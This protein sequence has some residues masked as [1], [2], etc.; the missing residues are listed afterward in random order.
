V[1]RWHR[2][3]A[4]TQIAALQAARAGSAEGTVYVAERQTSG[5]G[6]HGHAWESPAGAGLYC[7]VLLWPTRPIGDLLL[8]T[9]AAG[10]AAADAVG[11][12]CGLEAEIRWPNDL[13][14]AGS[15]FGGILIESAAESGR[16]CA[17]LGL[18]INLRPAALPPDVAGIA[19]ALDQHL[20]RPCDRWEL[21][22][23]LLARLAHRY[24]AWS[25]GDDAALRD[26][27]AARSRYAQGLAVAVGGANGYCG[28]TAGL[29][30]NGFLRVR[31]ASGE[32]RVVAS[33]DVRPQ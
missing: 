25:H 32:V 10:L 29:E 3:L 18:G 4:S 1:I 30:A 23:A 5:R 2:E 9:L 22:H 12:T 15:K 20:A 27:F 31:L 16:L 6:R 7:S 33:G 13:L 11:E 28:V 21:L 14:Y 26:E 17:A 8:L 19:T 24:R